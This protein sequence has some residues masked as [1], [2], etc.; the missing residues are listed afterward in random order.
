MLVT[1][2]KGLTANLELPK[3]SRREAG[4][5]FGRE[6]GEGVPQA[7]TRQGPQAR[8]ERDYDMGGRLGGQ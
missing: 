8:G 1:A 4:K 5:K 2:G 7:R 6:A 3:I